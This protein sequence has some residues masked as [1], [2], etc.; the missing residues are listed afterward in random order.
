[1]ACECANKS[2]GVIDFLLHPR[3]QYI[4]VELVRKGMVTNDVT[5]GMSTLRDVRIALDTAS[6]LE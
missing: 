3:L 1:M 2:L 4:L 6:D 5:G